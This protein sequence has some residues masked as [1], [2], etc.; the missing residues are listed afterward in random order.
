MRKLTTE[1]IT[2]HHKKIVL[3]GD[4]ARAVFYKLYDLF[5]SG[6]DFKKVTIVVED[7]ET[8][9]DMMHSVTFQI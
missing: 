9:G 1:K 2:D 7:N 5:E 4:Q 6:N 8:I 3:N